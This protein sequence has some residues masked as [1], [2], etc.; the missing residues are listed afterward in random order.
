[1]LFRPKDIKNKLPSNI[2]INLI[3]LEN[4]A[5]HIDK[6]IDRPAFKGERRLTIIARN[7]FFAQSSC[8]IP[9]L[10][11]VVGLNIF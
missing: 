9:Q 10:I 1:L 2:K 8:I 5:T 4:K 6:Y 3:K 7:I 11:T